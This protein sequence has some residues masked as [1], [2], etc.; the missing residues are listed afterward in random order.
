[1]RW[2]KSLFWATAIASLLI[3]R[4]TKFW[5]IETFELIKPPDAP[6]SWAVIPNVFHFTYVTNPGAAFSWCR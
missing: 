4:W 3:D 1:M 2:K 5:V 6:Q